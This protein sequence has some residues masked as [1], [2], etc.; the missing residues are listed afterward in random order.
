MS[1]TLLQSNKSNFGSI[2]TQTEG[3]NILVLLSNVPK[4]GNCIPEAFPVSIPLRKY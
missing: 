1:C 4:V 3:F 2:E